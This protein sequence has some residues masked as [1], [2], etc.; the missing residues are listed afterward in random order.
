[1]LLVKTVGLSKQHSKK[2]IGY[3]PKWDSVVVWGGSGNPSKQGYGLGD[4]DTTH[5]GASNETF[6]LH[7]Y[8]NGSLKAIDELAALDKYDRELFET[9]QIIAVTDSL[10]IPSSTVDG[11]ADVLK[12][13]KKWQDARY[14]ALKPDRDQVVSPLSHGSLRASC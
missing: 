5:G 10:V 12:A 7:Y 9:D 1:M 11:L 3:S 4:S 2:V 13:K 6:S 8:P 14:N